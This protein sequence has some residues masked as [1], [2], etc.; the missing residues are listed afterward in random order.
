[1]N[2]LVDLAKALDVPFTRLVEGID[3]ELAVTA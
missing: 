3:S 2:E 1:M